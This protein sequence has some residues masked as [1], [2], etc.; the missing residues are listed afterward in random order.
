MNDVTVVMPVYNEEACINEVID[1]WKTELDGPVH[2]SPVVC[3][4]IVY[5]QTNVNDEE[6]VSSVYGLWAANGSVAFKRQLEPAEWSASSVVIT[7]G[8]LLAA[9]DN[10][11]VYCYTQSDYRGDG[12]DGGEDG[13][14]E[15]EG[16][17]STPGFTLPVL[18]AALVVT[19]T[20]LASRTRRRN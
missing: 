13:G 5:V 19:I 18:A 3:G 11:R 4:N 17:G 16:E 8:Y 14:E 12:G 6:A 9:S 2:S 20:A 15:D 10:G 7:D 1:D